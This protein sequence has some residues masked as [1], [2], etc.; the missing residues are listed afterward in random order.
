MAKAEADAGELLHRILGL[1]SAATGRVRR[2]AVAEF[3]EATGTAP[4]RTET[5]VGRLLEGL[6][7]TSFQVLGEALEVPRDRLAELVGIAPRTLARRKVFKPE[8]S[9]RIFRFGRIYQDA[10]E[11]FNGQAEEARTWLKSPQFGLGGAIPLEFART[12]PGA[13]E[14]R[15]LIGR[16]NEGVFA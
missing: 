5:V 10:L 6:P 2:T 12:E 16:L 8:E 1:T 7:I 11:L 13:Q 3:P 4:L 15:A 14:V 9:D